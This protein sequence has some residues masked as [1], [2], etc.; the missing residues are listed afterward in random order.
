M[1]NHRFQCRAPPMLGSCSQ[2]SKTKILKFTWWVGLSKMEGLRLETFCCCL[3]V[4]KIPEFYGTSSMTAYHI[5]LNKCFFVEQITRTQTFLHSLTCRRSV[6]LIIR[7][8]ITFSFTTITI[9]TITYHISSTVT[10][11]CTCRGVIEAH[12][13]LK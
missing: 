5:S 3:L 12:L 6:V 1:L 11:M 4:I 13:L 8:C 2:N 9:T 7:S 10:I